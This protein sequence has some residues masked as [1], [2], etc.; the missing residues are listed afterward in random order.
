M[1]SSF[2]EDIISQFAI[3]ISLPLKICDFPIHNFELKIVFYF[4]GSPTK[5][6]STN[7]AVSVR[8]R[9]DPRMS[10]TCTP[11]MAALFATPIPSLRPMIPS[12]IQF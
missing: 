7:C 12:G 10:P 1:S 2:L 5:R 11:P 6:P 3:E 4:L 8:S 9:L